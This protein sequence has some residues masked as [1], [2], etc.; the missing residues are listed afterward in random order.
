M[1]ATAAKAF[2]AYAIN[3]N[4]NEGDRLRAK[5]ASMAISAFN[6]CKIGAKPYEFV[7]I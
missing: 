6:G 1:L 4:R 3:T 7:N 2:D 5:T